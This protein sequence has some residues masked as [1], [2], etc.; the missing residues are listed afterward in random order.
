M[1]QIDILPVVGYDQLISGPFYWWRHPS[2]DVQPLYPSNLET[3][4]SEPSL[5]AYYWTGEPDEN[6]KNEENVRLRSKIL[7][8]LRVQHQLCHTNQ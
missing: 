7:L 6:R 1:L 8:R 2:S 3:P 5:S 4:L